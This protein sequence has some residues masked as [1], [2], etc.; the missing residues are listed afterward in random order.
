MRSPAMADERRRGLPLGV[1][2]ALGLTAVAAAT[3]L[4]L[5]WYLA[6]RTTTAFEARGE[7]LIEQSS[8][9]LTDLAGSSAAASRQ[10]L[11]DLIRHTTDA[12]QRTLADMPLSL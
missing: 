1:K 6:P 7:A 10:V 8:E 5:S 2:L 4:L 12:R 9:A 11:I 3:V